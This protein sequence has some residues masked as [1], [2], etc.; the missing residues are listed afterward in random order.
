VIAFTVLYILFTM[1]ASELFSFT[2]EDDGALEFKR[3]E[4]AKRKVKIATAST[5][6]EKG[7]KEQ[8]PSGGSSESSG[9]LDGAREEEAL[10]EISGSESIFT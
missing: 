7:S 10:Q 2:A 5:D 4:A 9:T 8:I 1:I 6:V 3:S